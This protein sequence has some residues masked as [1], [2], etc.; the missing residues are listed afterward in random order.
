MVG[1]KDGLYHTATGFPKL[2]FGAI[3]GL[4][5]SAHASL[6][7]AELRAGEV[8]RMFSPATS[9]VIEVEIVKGKVSKI[10]ARKTLDE[11][12]DLCYVFLTETKVVKTV[13]I[14]DKADKHYTL[15]KSR[16]TRP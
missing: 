14:N 7:A 12:R 15:D 10:L 5:P 3:L 13:W 8:P 11:T 6:R 4:V 16:F 2:T 1:M 9:K